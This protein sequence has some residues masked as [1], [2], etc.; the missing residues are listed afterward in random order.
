MIFAHAVR[1]GLRDR[2]PARE[3]GSAKETKRDRYITDDELDT[4]RAAIVASADDKTSSARSFLCL[5]D[6][7]YQTAQRIGDL[8]AL[9][10]QDVSDDGISFRPSQTVNRSGVRL[11]IEMT[12][13]LQET[14]N[15]ARG[16]KI[17]SIGPV[18]C[19][20]AGGRYT[21]I[22]AYS[23]WK[24]ACLRA[25]SAYEKDCKKKG[26]T[27]N[28]KYLIGMHFH[29]LRAKA[30]TDPKRQQGAAAAQSLAGHT[31]ESMT[32]PLHE[33]A[34]SGTRPASPH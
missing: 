9:N 10:W 22:G 27:P 5:I 30:L 18:I 26:I 16:G 20:H 8:L 13:D 19:A 23:G 2:N 29:D 3:I 32:A 33:I 17:A 25:R 1:R 4:V 34:R 15:R 28:P 24:R 12:P 11:L 21:Y 14:L 6:L 7:A 31:T